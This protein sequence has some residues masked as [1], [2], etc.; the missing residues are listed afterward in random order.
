[1]NRTFFQKTL[2]VGG[3][4]AV[5]ACC[6]S[7]STNL[8]S[9]PSV[10]PQVVATFWTSELVGELVEVENC[11]RMNDKD[12]NSSFLLIWPPDVI[13]TTDKANVRVVIGV[14]AGNRKEVVLRIGELVRLSGGEITNL[15]E[16]LRYTLPA[17][18]PGPYWI[19]GTEVV[20]L[21]SK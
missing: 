6:Q 12:S 13:A 21:E 1:M 16:Q 15:D 19:V 5:T 2:L 7:L 8:R 4:L 10:T 18:C 11:L 14:T 9:T 3:L 17:N 20:P